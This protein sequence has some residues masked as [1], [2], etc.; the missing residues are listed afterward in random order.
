MISSCTSRV[1]SWPITPR[2]PGKDF[3]NRLRALLGYLLLVRV[4][5]VARGCGFVFTVLRMVIGPSRAIAGVG[6]ASGYFLVVGQIN[7]HG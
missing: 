1:T 2:A 3:V 7:R 6:E 5:G 4:P